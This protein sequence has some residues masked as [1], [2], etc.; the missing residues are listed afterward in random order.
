MTKICPVSL[1]VARLLFFFVSF[2]EALP[3]LLG[4]Y[5]LHA[6]CRWTIQE[7]TLV[8]VF[9]HRHHTTLFDFL[10]MRSIQLWKRWSFPV[11]KS[12]FQR[13]G[14]RHQSRWHELGMSKK[15]CYNS[16]KLSTKPKLGEV[17]IS[18]IF[19]DIHAHNPNYWTDIIT[20]VWLQL[21]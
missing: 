7:Q 19:L 18:Y 15:L 17:L 9:H 8:A 5:F 11:F 14:L 16:E 10:P 13:Q 12:V 1:Y 21:G 3:G 6:A 2:W 20:V 4:F